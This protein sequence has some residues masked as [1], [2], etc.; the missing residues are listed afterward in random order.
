MILYLI[1]TRKDIGLLLCLGIN[2]KESLKI[3]FVHSFLITIIGAV[4]ACLQL[5]I[6]FVSFKFGFSKLFNI[7]VDLN[8]SFLPY[9]VIFVFSL[10][11]GFL[12]AL[13]LIKKVLKLNPLECL[14]N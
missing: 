10:I 3:L 7:S 14:K 13:F 6:I 4:S 8:F 5:L 2:K 11:T 9:L 12:S 1:E